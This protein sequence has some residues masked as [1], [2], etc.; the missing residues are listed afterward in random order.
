VPAGQ[1]AADISFKLFV[2]CSPQYRYFRRLLILTH[3]LVLTVLSAG[4]KQQ[5]PQGDL[6]G[7]NGTLFSMTGI[8]IVTPSWNQTSPG[9]ATPVTSLTTGTIVGIVVAGALLI[10]GAAALFFLYWRRQK[11]A[12]ENSYSEYRPDSDHFR[13]IKSISSSY[14]GGTVP[15]YTTDYKSPPANQRNFELY[16]KIKTQHVVIPE[17]RAYEAAPGTAGPATAAL[18]GRDTPLPTRQQLLSPQI[19][20]TPMS[21][22]ITAGGMH[23]P[24]DGMPTHPAFI[25][26]A[27]TRASRNPMSQ[28]EAKPVVKANKPDAYALQRY[29]DTVED[30]SKVD[31]KT[32]LSPP[33]PVESQKT[34]TTIVSVTSNPFATPQGTPMDIPPAPPGP[35]PRSTPRST[36]KANTSSKLTPSLVNPSLSRIRKPKMYI[37]P[38]L[39]IS[40][41]KPTAQRVDSDSDESK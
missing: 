25:P 13:Q 33:P 20:N 35:P 32:L 9:T 16:D 21:Q 37:P 27:F 22:H 15:F 14:S 34:R 40:S 29:L 12:K 26:R 5:P 41:A 23:E 17:R 39:N 30:L 4:C 11:R 7:L 36:P 19:A 10:F 1:L 38:P 31:I 2:H 28:P 6:L 18:W 8:S 3:H 24:L